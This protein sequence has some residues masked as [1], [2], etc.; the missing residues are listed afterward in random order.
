MYIELVKL[1]KPWTNLDNQIIDHRKSSAKS[2]SHITWNFFL[3]FTISNSD[4]WRRGQSAFTPLANCTIAPKL[5][6]IITLAFI[7]IPGL[8]SEWVKTDPSNALVCLEQKKVRE[9]SQKVMFAQVINIKAWSFN[10]N[11]TGLL[12]SS[13]FENN[14]LQ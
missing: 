1:W 5:S 4:I 3:G 10:I 9:A 12:I 8:T 14:D 7:T 11:K 6:T 2:M 13:F